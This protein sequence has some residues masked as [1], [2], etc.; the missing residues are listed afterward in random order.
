MAQ[1]PWLEPEPQPPTGISNS[2]TA[3]VWLAAGGLVICTLLF[4][5]LPLSMAGLAM[6]GN[7]SLRVTDAAATAQQI[8]RENAA[9][10]SGGGASPTTST[11][12]TPRA[13]LPAEADPP[14][15]AAVRFSESF[16]T[17]SMG[18]QHTTASH[19]DGVSTGS[20]NQGLYEFSI[21]G[22]TENRVWW[23]YPK[24]RTDYP[25]IPADF[26]VTVRARQTAGEPD[27]GYGLVLN[28]SDSDD[29]W[30]TFFIADTGY[31]Q[32][33]N[34]KGGQTVSVLYWTQSDAINPGDWNEVSAA[35]Q[36]GKVTFSVNGQ[37]IFVTSGL[38]ELAGAAGVAA[39]VYD[40]ERH[41]FQFDDFAVY[42]TKP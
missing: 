24:Q 22:D 37:T 20:I 12:G 7:A 15:G 17:V 10:G 11:G 1:D 41:T 14:A 33:L 27:G 2:G 23:T 3:I 39:S 26:Y 4:I 34:R 28:A 25:L 32:V 19:N 40:R 18:W 35:G 8:T 16:D 30:V 21:I 29:G 31:V 38:P 42:D 5:L 6:V 9:A 36:D 13:S